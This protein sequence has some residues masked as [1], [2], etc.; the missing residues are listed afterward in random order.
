VVTR[1]ASLAMASPFMTGSPEA[2]LI[3]RTPQGRPGGPDRAAEALVALAVLSQAKGD[4]PATLFPGQDGDLSVKISNSNTGAIQITSV[5]L[6]GTITLDV[7]GGHCD[8]S[9]VTWNGTQ[10]GTS[11]ASPPGQPRSLRFR[12]PSTWPRTL[13]PLARTCWPRSQSEGEQK[14]SEGN[15]SSGS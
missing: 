3:R 1:A 13:Q 4:V 11:A 5:A 2:T 9:F 8:S 14:P 15:F 10:G 12:G 7:G 6:S